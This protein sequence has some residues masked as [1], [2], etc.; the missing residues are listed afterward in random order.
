MMQ[1][2]TPKIFATNSRNLKLK[3]LVGTC[4]NNLLMPLL[5]AA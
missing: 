5:A 4:L 2:D 1:L 3:M